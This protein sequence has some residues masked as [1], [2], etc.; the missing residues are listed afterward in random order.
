MQQPEKYDRRMTIMNEFQNN[1]IT[2]EYLA[3]IPFITIRQL[4]KC[5]YFLIQRKNCIVF[6]R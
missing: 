2:I 5:N 6:A 1:I 3:S 4:K